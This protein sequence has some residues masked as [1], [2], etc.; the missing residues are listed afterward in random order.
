MPQ[1]ALSE[2]KSIGNC[3]GIGPGFPLAIFVVLVRL[4]ALALFSA[5]VVLGTCLLILVPLTTLGWLPAL[6]LLTTLTLLAALL[7]LVR[8]YFLVL[9]D[10]PDQSEARQPSRCSICSLGAQRYGAVSPSELLI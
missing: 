5:L 6:A 9:A 7:V 10:S 1:G 3:P 2:H 4:A 8:H